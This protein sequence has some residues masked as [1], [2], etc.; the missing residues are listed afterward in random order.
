MCTRRG[1]V[2]ARVLR[3]E[4]VVGV[5]DQAAQEPTVEERAHLLA[6]GAG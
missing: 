2:R 6:R 3:L 1:C 5:L 4:A